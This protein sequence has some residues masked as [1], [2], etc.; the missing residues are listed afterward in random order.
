MHKEGSLHRVIFLCQY[1]QLAGVEQEAME[2]RVA[3]VFGLCN[4][5]YKGDT[6]LTTS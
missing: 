5:H 3:S 4:F 2:I 6:G 1:L